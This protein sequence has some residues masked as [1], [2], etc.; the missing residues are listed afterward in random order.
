MIKTY[1]LEKRFIARLE[2]TQSLFGYISL[3]AIV[4]S[5]FKH[6]RKNNNV[7]IFKKIYSINK[8]PT[9]K[10]PPSKQ[11]RDMLQQQK[12]SRMANRK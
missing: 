9:L 4:N 5:Y 12:N 2:K 1:S 6:R 11:F 8:T 7:I 10:N 3:E